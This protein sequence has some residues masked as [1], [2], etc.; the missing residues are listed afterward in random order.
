MGKPKPKRTIMK[1]STTNTT[2]YYHLIIDKSGSM[3][4]S[5]DVT[6]S[7]VKEQL[8]AI[9]ALTDR[10]AGQKILTGIT[11]F[12]EQIEHLYFYEDI[13]NLQPLT[14]QEYQPSGLTALLDAIGKTVIGLECKV[15]NQVHRAEASVVVVVIT[16]GYENASSVFTYEQIRTMIGSLEDTGLWSF[17]YLGANL[18]DISDACRMGFKP[19]SIRLFDREEI[20]H[21]SSVL[22][23]SL[24]EYVV[25]KEANT[26]DDAPFIIKDE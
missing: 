4:D 25:R 24:E 14:A 10:S 23:S 21:Y 5:V 18:K 17:T 19:S 20:Q 11:L 9:K 15:Q 22:A 3:H 13:H 16:D 7:T 26:G 2:T 8:Q 6:L 12:N 1:N